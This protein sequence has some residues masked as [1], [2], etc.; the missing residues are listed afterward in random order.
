MRAVVD[1]FEKLSLLKYIG[2]KD[3]NITFGNDKIVFYFLPHMIEEARLGMR[4]FGYSW[5]AVEFLAGR[6]AGYQFV[7][8]HGAF[9]GKELSQ[10][11][12]ISQQTLESFGW[13]KFSTWRFDKK[14]MYL[15]INGERSTLADELKAMYGPQKACVDF[16]LAG[17]FA[18]AATF[19]T[20]T[21][22]YCVE[23]ECRVQKNINSCQFVA[24]GKDKIQKYVREFFPTK[25]K[26]VK[27]CLEQM[28]IIE[29]KLGDR[30]LEW[31]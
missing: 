25:V 9:L 21:P 17:L 3:G 18:G 6:F 15:L 30:F 4:A 12:D 26:M 20:K 22:V 31:H 14:K 24:A 2:F 10:V 29:K 11:I 19:Y 7:K 8:A 5:G 23:L 28:R 1:Y 13:G 16:F 27:T